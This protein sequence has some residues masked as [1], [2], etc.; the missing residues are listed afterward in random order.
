M[1]FEQVLSPGRASA[2]LVAEMPVAERQLEL[3]GI[4]TGVLE[5]GAGPPVVL[6]HGPGEYA[7][8]WMRV[9]PHLAETHRVV[10]P[11]LPGHGRSTVGDDPLDR[12]RIVAWT[13]E[14]IDETCPSPPAM[15]GLILGGAIAARFAVDHSDRLSQLVLVD[16][17]G[18][19]PF[20]PHPE[21][22]RA[23]NEFLEDPNQQTHQSLWQQ[24]AFDLDAL[25]SRMGER[26]EPFES[27]NIDRARS[28]N[29]QLA[30][31]SLMGEFGFPAIPDHE[32]E[33]IAAPTTLIWGRHD[34]ATAL[35]VAETASS[36]YGWPLHVIENSA[37]DPPIEQPEAFLRAV[38]LALDAR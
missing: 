24:C 29:T 34:L 6:L 4:S 16:S 31:N 3:A 32:L 28:S 26:W 7:A 13:G 38:H 18:L 15:V 37:D 35:Q 14:L 20:D 17:L 36:R 2:P 19:V 10:A 33:K 11:D 21:F 1:T 9:I 12:E 30:L 25:K 5:G 23:L 8:K 27:Y 22:G